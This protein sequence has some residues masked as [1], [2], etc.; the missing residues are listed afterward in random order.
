MAV[1]LLQKRRVRQ[2]FV[3]TF[4]IDDGFLDSPVFKL[5]LR[6]LFIKKR[7]D[8]FLL[9]KAVD[10]RKGAVRL[11]RA[12][13]SNRARIPGR[14]ARIVVGI[15]QEGHLGLQ[16]AHKLGLHPFVHCVKFFGKLVVFFGRSF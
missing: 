3:R 6:L 13:K 15:A 4:V 12:V 1:L 7:I 10:N 8:W 11:P 2:Q 16:I 5:D 14:K 9:D